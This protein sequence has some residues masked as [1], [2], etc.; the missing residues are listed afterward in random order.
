VEGFE[1][2][3]RGDLNLGGHDI[4]EVSGRRG[5]VFRFR[6]GSQEVEECLEGNGAVEF[7]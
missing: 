1:S 4:V 3:I 2:V 6:R 7:P 5:E